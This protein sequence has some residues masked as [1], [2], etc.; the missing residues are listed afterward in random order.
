VVNHTIDTVNTDFFGAAINASNPVP[1]PFANLRNGSN[2]YVTF[3]AARDLGDPL[4]DGD[5]D[6]MSDAAETAAGRDS[7]D[8]ADLAFE[9]NTN[10]DFEGWTNSALTSPAVSGGVLTGTASSSSTLTLEGLYL[11]GNAISNILFRETASK[12]ATVKLRWAR[13]DD[14]TYDSSLREISLSLAASTPKSLVAALSS[15][16]EWAGRTITGLRILPASSSTT[17]VTL[18]W[19][20]T[21]TGD[22]DN[23][24]IPDSPEFSDGYDA[25][26]AADALLDLDGDGSNRLAEYIWGTSDANGSSNFQ[27]DFTMPSSGDAILSWDGLAGRNYRVWRSYTLAV[28]SWQQIHET[29]A[30]STNQ[31]I[32]IEDEESSEQNR[33]F[34]R[35]EAEIANP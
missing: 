34:Y 22:F 14:H 24:G 6:G 5:F 31:T 10:G 23:D 29:G 9:F 2:G 18:D 20:R 19:V 32:Q 12:A 4:R 35:I 7:A 26:D 17:S 16:P 3:R 33:A 11:P 15:H 8:P 27:T 28:D 13:A 30:L 21:S 1:G 25:A